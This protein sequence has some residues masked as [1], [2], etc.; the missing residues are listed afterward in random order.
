MEGSVGACGGSFTL[1]A[2]LT[3]GADAGIGAAAQSGWPGGYVDVPAVEEVAFPETATPVRWDRLKGRIQPQRAPA[4]HKM[5]ASR[6]VSPDRADYPAK[7]IE[8]SEEFLPSRS[9]ACL[10]TQPPQLLCEQAR[11]LLAFQSR[12]SMAFGLE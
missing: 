6:S 11:L 12:I 10:R 3:E 4:S 1:A 8:R 2:C 7:P 9:T 5:S